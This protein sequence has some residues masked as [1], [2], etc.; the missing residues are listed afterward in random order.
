MLRLLAYVGRRLLYLLPQA[1]GI[2]IVTF[3]IVRE[4]PGNPAYM[5]AGP[6]ATTEMIA[7]LQKDMGLDQPIWTQYW[8]YLRSILHG[9][10]GSS[11]VTSN[12]VLVDLAKRVPATLELISLGLFFSLAIGIPLGAIAALR[13]RRRSAIKTAANIYGSLA[14][15][16][17]DFWLGLL[18]IFVFYGKLHWL[19]PPMGRV[20]LSVIP[21]ARVTG[22]LTIDSL[23]AGDGEAFASAASHLVLPVVTLVFVYMAPIVK[24]TRSSMEEVLSSDYIDYSVAL[25][26]PRGSIFRRAL[27]NALP[28]VVT[29]FGV[30]Y[31]YLLGGA[32]LVESVFAWGGVGQYAVQSIVNADFAAIQA[33]VL[34]AAAFTLMVYLMVDLI[35]F[36]LD[37]RLRR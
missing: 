26:L 1:I 11:W 3:I 22:F 28:P 20:D 23:I 27:H 36:A 8:I 2:S 16:V 13:Q 35:Y 9:D 14:G 34:I 25:G 24:M 17:P 30:L 4:L 10:F 33:F 32:V 18:L 5:I 31:G 12:P 6:R 15:A 21:P 19:P 37:P 7:K 29:I